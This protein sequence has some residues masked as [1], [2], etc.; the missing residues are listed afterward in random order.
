MK[1]KGKKMKER[2][3]MAQSTRHKCSTFFGL[4]VLVLKVEICI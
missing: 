2:K 3:H 1:E 4:D